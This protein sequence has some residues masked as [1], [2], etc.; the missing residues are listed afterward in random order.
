MATTARYTKTIINAFLQQ[1]T[2]TNMLT[3]ADIKNIRSLS[4]ASERRARRLFVAEGEKVI[5]Q[6]IEGGAV[7]ERL[8]YNCDS[9]IA[10]Q[11]INKYVD[12]AG[13]QSDF[14]AERITAEQMSRIS[15]LKTPSKLLAVVRIPDFTLRDDYASQ[16]LSLVLDTVQDPGNMGTIIRLADWFGIKEVFCSRESADCFSQKVVQSTMG[17]ISRVA[18]HYVNLGEL[19]SNSEKPIYGTF[20]DGENIYTASIPD[21]QNG[22]IVMGSEGQGISPDLGSYIKNRLYIP[23]ADPNCV[24]SLNV[25]VATAIICSYFHSLSFR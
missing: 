15:Q 3:K 22:Y 11:L 1:P 4:Q 24:E 18:V 10:D 14:E 8:Y 13:Q 17:A 5:E 9:Q 16:G 25:A 21:F 7:I 6:L 23:A 2:K 12:K 19:L 20:L